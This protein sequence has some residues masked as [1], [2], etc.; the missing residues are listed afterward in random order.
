MTPIDFPNNDHYYLALAEEAFS[1][2]DYL[3]AL[4][5]YKYAYQEN[6]TPKLN[7]LIA[8]LALEQGDFSAALE[9]AEEE[10]ESYLDTPETIDLFLQIQ[11]YS[12][13]FF[14]AREFLWRSQKVKILTE[15][16]TDLWLMRIND[17]EAFYERQQQAVI[18]E[19]EAELNQL[20][21]MSAVDQL[22]FVRK[23][24]QLPEERLKTIAEKFMMTPQIVPLVRSYLFES[25]AR[26]G[27]TEKVHYLT[28]QD[29]IAELSPIDSGF[30][31]SLQSGIETRLNDYLG[32]NNPILL[33]N[34]LEQVKVEMAFLYPLHTAF[35]KPDAWTASYLAEYS[36]WSGPLDEEVEA[37]RG[38]IKQLLFDYH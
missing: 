24:R 12:Q 17:Q 7:H 11:V 10:S 2:G 32:D 9:Y 1:A 20:P 13:N 16:Q 18:K 6:P 29:E 4:E 38:R 23:I 14:A 28:I 3:R 19:L 30:D 34:L 25:L 8:G 37:I 31:D 15:E 22:L 35:M 27:V 26:I 5:N 21:S 36:E 33:A